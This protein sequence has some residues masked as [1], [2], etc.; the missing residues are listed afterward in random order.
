MDAYLLHD[1]RGQIGHLAHSE[2]LVS[3]YL[4]NST[5]ESHEGPCDLSRFNEKC[6]S[7]FVLDETE[8][9]ERNHVV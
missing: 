2:S 7:V 6:Y 1:C 3:Y 9:R 5:R 8:L 4:R